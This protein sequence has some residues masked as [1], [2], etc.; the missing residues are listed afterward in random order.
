MRV[1]DGDGVSQGVI[2]KEGKSAGIRGR[3]HKIKNIRMLDENSLVL[4]P[5]LT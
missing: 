2:N 1:K 3:S 4:F 5:L